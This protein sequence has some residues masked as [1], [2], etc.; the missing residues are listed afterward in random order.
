MDPIYRFW[1]S[2]KHGQCVCIHTSK[3]TLM[4]MFRNVFR[5]F[6]NILV[7]TQW[8]LHPKTD[9]RIIDKS[10]RNLVSLHIDFGGTSCKNR[11]RFLD[12]KFD[13][14]ISVELE[15][16]SDRLN[17]TYKS[18]SSAA[19]SPGRTSS[20][21]NAKVISIQLW[22]AGIY[23]IRLHGNTLHLVKITMVGGNFLE[24]V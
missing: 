3:M 19:S 22:C 15:Q 6:N 9:R 18:V 1:L 24:D 7:G 10:Q 4:A 8:I 14:L 21:S 5:T 12:S 2:T 13:C 17:K 23:S 20:R 11:G 16:L